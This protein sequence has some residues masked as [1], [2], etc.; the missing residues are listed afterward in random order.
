MSM[1][2]HVEIHKFMPKG[3][4][5]TMQCATCNKSFLFTLRQETNKFFKKL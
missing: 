4:N 2:C 3:N 1:T 5:D